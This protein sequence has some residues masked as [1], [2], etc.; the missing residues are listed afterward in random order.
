[1]TLRDDIKSRL[2]VDHE[3][4][5]RCIDQ[6][7]A[8]CFELHL[9]VAIVSGLAIA[10]LVAIVALMIIHVLRRRRRQWA[11]VVAIFFAAAP[12]Y[13]P[14]LGLMRM[15]FEYPMLFIFTMLWL[16]VILL[17]AIAVWYARTRKD[18]KRCDRTGKVVMGVLSVIVVG[19]V[20]S[21]GILYLTA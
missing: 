15:K 14:I 13:V 19:S 5:T 4:P 2:V 8:M 9:A 18:S 16:T 11:N 17:P 21:A 1:M 20:V 10:S 6:G 12:V 3:L 7:I